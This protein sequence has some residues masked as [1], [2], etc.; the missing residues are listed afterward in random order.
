M[1]RYW[2]SGFD[3]KVALPAHDEPMKK[4]GRSLRAQN[5][6]GQKQV[7]PTFSDVNPFYWQSS[8]FT[9]TSWVYEWISCCVPKTRR[10]R[11][12]SPL[13]KPRETKKKD[14]FIFRR[15]IIVFPLF[16]LEAAARLLTI[17]RLR[18]VN[19][20]FQYFCLSSD[21][22]TDWLTAHPSLRFFC[23]AQG[24]TKSRSNTRLA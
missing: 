18:K 23:Q 10:H 11:H 9:M 4:P 13:L 2:F 12:D 16:L 24:A 6:A 1:Q 14:P 17:S 8:Q 21:W 7:E 20:T 15:F 22:L 3:N 5:L 19:K